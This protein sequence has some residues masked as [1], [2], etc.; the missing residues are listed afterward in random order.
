MPESVGDI[1][2]YG[3][4]GTLEV[5]IVKFLEAHPG[6]G[7]T[8]SEIAEAVAGRASIFNRARVNRALNFLCSRKRIR[9]TSLEGRARY[10]IEMGSI[11]HLYQELH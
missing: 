10:S 6:L 8:T 7:Y 2:A 1:A 3:G 11:G 4:L 5:K 9:L